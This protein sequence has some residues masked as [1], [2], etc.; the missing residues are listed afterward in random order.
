MSSWLTFTHLL[1]MTDGFLEY[2]ANTIILLADRC[3]RSELLKERSDLFICL[4]LILHL[5]IFINLEFVISN[6]FIV[7]RYCI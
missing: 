4:C 1:M 6:Y 5:L 3:A 2:S 7:K